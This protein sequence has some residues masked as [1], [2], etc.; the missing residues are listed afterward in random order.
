MEATADCE[1]MSLRAREACSLI[2]GM[3]V[4][5]NGNA[6]HTRQQFL[7]FDTK[8]KDILPSGLILMLF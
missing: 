2:C 6:S 4:G 3:E 7:S 1:V 5:Y 8:L